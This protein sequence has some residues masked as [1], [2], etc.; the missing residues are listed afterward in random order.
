MT[1]SDHAEEFGGVENVPRHVITMGIGTIMDA[2]MCLLLAFGKQKATVVAQTVEGP[3]T[4]MVPASI[5]Q[6]H[7]HATVL[8]DEEA[9]SELRLA[10]YYRHV[11]D[12]KPEWRKP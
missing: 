4:A 6:M 9:A 11:F 1:R 8:V 12:Q 3:V 5:L 10:D 2:G 7:E